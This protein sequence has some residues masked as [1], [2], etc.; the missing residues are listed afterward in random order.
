[1]HTWTEAGPLAGQGRALSSPRCG[2][3]R[4]VPTAGRSTASPRPPEDARLRNG[5]KTLADPEVEV[6]ERGCAELDHNIIR[7][8]LGIRRLLVAEHLGPAV[9]M[10]S[11]GFHVTIRP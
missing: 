10:D 1:M 2:P 9:L 7:A 6:V 5:G 11:H 3:A 4:G 8:G